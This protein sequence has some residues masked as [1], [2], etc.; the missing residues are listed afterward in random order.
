MNTLHNKDSGEFNANSACR[1][2]VSNIECT[3]T[4]GTLLVLYTCKIKFYNSMKLIR[5]QAL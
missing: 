3:G 2:R 4:T 1:A 5:L